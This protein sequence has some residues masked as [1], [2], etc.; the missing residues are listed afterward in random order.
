MIKKLEENS[1]LFAD[2]LYDTYYHFCLTKQQKF[3]IIVSGKRSRNNKVVSDIS[4]NDQI[5]EA[6]KTVCP[7]YVSKEE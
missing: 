1:L 2:D 6:S 7:Y 5:V 4:D 3:H